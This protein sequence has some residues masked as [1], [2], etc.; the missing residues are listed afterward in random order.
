MRTRG[1][2]HGRDIRN[3]LSPRQIGRTPQSF[4]EIVESAVRFLKE[5]W[6]EELGKLRWR[7][8]DMPGA[9]NEVGVPRWRADESKMLITLYRVPIERMTHLRRTDVLDERFHTEQFVFTAAA[10]LI[11]KDPW[12]LLPERFRN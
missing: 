1:S 8:V 10:S 12:D 3:R 9:E 7:V 6:P 2:R 11:G 5:E 4:E